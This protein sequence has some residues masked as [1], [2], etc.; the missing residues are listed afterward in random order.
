MTTQ[1]TENGRTAAVSPIVPVP[2]R[3][4]RWLMQCAAA[5][6]VLGATAAASSASAQSTCDGSSQ[7]GQTGNGNYDDS[8]TACGSSA[9][10]WGGTDNVAIGLAT[11]ASGGV[12][13]ISVGSGSQ[14]SGTSA[15][16][17]GSLYDAT[18][19]V[20]TRANTVVGYRSSAGGDN[21]GNTVLGSFANG[22]GSS[23]LNVALGTGAASYG[24]GSTNIAIGAATAIGDATS[25]I[26]I[27]DF[28][29]AGGFNSVAMGYNARAN[30]AFSVAVGAGSVAD[31]DFTFSVGTLTNRR[32]IAN[33]ANGA[34]AAGGAD[35]V[36][37]GQLFD[38]NQRVTALESGAANALGVAQT[39]QQSAEAAQETATAALFEA[40]YARNA[41]DAAQD[42]ADT[43]RAEAAAAQSTADTALVNA[44]TAQQT[45]DTAIVRGDTVGESVASALGGGATYDAINAVI[46]APTYGVG[47]A[48][49]NNVGDA[50]AAIN[51][52][53]TNHFRTDG[54]LG[55][56]LAT[57]AGSTAM[58][59]ESVASGS[60]S[61]AA[62]AGAQATGASSV[63]MGDR[64]R[65]T[66]AGAVAVGQNSAAT[67]V[68]AIAIGN[69]ATAT[70]SVAVGA[71]ASAANGGA[72]FGDGA[73]ATGLNAT[74]TGPNAQAL[75]ANSTAI[76]SG[77][78]A[79]QANTISV[80]AVGAERRMV[81]V[82]AGVAAT[83]AANVGQ[84]GAS[85]AS[86]A[87]ALGGGA[88]ANAAGV[89]TSPRYALYMG[90]FDNVGSALEGVSNFASDSRLEARRGIAAA[91]A[92][93]SAPMP[94][95]PGK[96]SWTLNA[97]EFNGEAALGGS[98]AHRFGRGDRPLAV[99]AGFSHS[100]RESAFRVGMSGEF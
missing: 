31:G 84:L 94:S 5:A 60:R 24:T 11:F 27:G 74:A 29:V 76:G 32:R 69:G 45:A 33:V 14:A 7:V 41:A 40:F 4:S 68:N 54:S 98:I 19:L 21:S 36:T 25:K 100:G 62:G 18:N 66:A 1:A 88:T 85:G 10:T 23:S 50:F 90:S 87:A 81:N 99:S 59:G 17:L 52:T 82:A 28:S 9:T 80:G 39:A 70:G 64:A 91:M 20:A 83:D 12:G 30:G 15:G 38:T 2:A 58:G 92:M 56:A 48:F 75:A 13:H 77:S 79:D 78:V 16:G 89:I 8:Q 65:A 35:A 43:A 49:Y 73:V 42:T 3:R 97:A 86:V 37:G 55:L 22:S 51:Q 72:A 96:T 47:G 46:T 53:G 95:A 61:I 26:S 67:G 34:I 93:S 57:G 71:L 44:A 6:L 63:A